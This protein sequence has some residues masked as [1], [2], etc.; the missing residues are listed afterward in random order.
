MV[1]VINKWYYTPIFRNR[2][3]I[4]TICM[5]FPFLN[6]KRKYTNELCCTSFTVADAGHIGPKLL[7]GILEIS[8]ELQNSEYFDIGR[9]IVLGWRW[10]SVS[11][12]YLDAVY[13]PYKSLI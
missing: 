8:V 6:L 13:L 1:K 10:P 4:C 12:P 5:S 2:S 7:S 11:H 3:T 9:L